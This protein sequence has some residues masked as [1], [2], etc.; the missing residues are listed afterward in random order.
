MHSKIFI[1]QTLA[2]FTFTPSKKFPTIKIDWFFAAEIIAIFTKKKFEL[3]F[4][5]EADGNELPKTTQELTP[6]TVKK[7]LRGATVV[8][9]NACKMNSS[10]LK[11]VSR[12]KKR[13]AEG[14]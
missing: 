2:V 11:R 8:D 1:C 6:K 13:N 3:I 9:P 4:F 7:I 5:V 10:S 12:P 14:V